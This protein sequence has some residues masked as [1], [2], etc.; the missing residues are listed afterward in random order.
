MDDR[1]ENLETGDGMNDRAKKDKGS[2][3]ATVDGQRDKRQ[4]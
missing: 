1:V 2:A 3:V 4:Q